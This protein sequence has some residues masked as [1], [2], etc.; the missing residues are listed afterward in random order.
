MDSV[1][2][3]ETRT[4]YGRWRYV[5]RHGR[6]SQPAP[7]LA[8]VYRLRMNPRRTRVAEVKI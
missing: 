8:V 6:H 4:W 1:F 7:L 3:I 2:R 5:R